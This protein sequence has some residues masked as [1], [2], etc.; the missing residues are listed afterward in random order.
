MKSAVSSSAVSTNSLPASLRS[1]IYQSM[2]V[3]LFR[4]AVSFWKKLLPN[5][6]GLYLYRKQHLLFRSGTNPMAVGLSNNRPSSDADIAGVGFPGI[7]QTHYQRKRLAV[8]SISRK[9][10]VG[11]YK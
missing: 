6:Q 7:L 10:K 4:G 9:I 11:V 2:R 1:E 5:S 3:S 8:N